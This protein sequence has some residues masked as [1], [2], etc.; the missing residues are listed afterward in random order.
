MPVTFFIPGPLRQF[1]DGRQQV[2]VAGTFT[3]LRDAFSALSALHPGLRDRV[4]TEQG[5]IREHVNL[6]VGNDCVRY[7]DGL[8]TSV[9]EGSE[10]SIVP[11]VSGGRSSEDEE[12]LFA[13]GRS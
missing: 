8:E 10:I 1:T 13:K 4:L 12:H 11:A 2:A 7:G 6:F 9:P 5:D 3:T